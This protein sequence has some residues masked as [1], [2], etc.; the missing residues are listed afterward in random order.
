VKPTRL[1]A[2]SDGV[3]AIIIT[4]MVLELKAPANDGDGHGL[5]R[6][7]PVLGCYTLSFIF[8]AIYW[9][10]HHHLIPLAREVDAAILWLNLLL[11][12]CLSLVPFATAYLGESHLS[13]PAVALYGAVGAAGG[14]AFYLLR[15]AIARHHRADER[16]RR[17]HA[18]LLLKN[19][20]AIMIYLASIPAAWWQPWIALG[21]IALPAIMYFV[22]DRQAESAAE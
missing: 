10:N 16:L 12:F 21:L 20:I 1:E 7:L 22:P 9:V 11:L 3:I 13:T 18:Q 14:I 15:W 8:V 19:R 5:L 17:L 6:V 4:I 2:F